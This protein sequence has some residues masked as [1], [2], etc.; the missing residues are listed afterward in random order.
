MQQLQLV[1]PLGRHPLATWQS[2]TCGLVANDMADAAACSADPRPTRERDDFHLSLQCGVRRQLMCLYRHSQAR[3]TLAWRCNAQRELTSRKAD[4]ACAS[5]IRLTK[6]G[7][8]TS[9]PLFN[10]HAEIEQDP[11][12][13]DAIASRKQKIFLASAYLGQQQFASL[14]FSR[15]GH[16][17]HGNWFVSLGR[18]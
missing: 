3:A 9:S 14:F 7:I 6:R 10:S 4:P 8:V 11:A 16:S 1:R 13:V 18:H 12:I 17:C 2:E 5:P 15:R